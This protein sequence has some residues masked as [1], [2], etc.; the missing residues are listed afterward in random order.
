MPHEQAMSEKRHP[1]ECLIHRGLGRVEFFDLS[2]EHMVNLDPLLD[3]FSAEGRD[4]FSFHAPIMRPDDFP[5][6]GV[7]CFFLSEEK[8]LR[9]KSFSLL[10]RTLDEARRWGADYVVSHLT[11]GPSDTKN[12]DTALKL[13]REACARMAVMSAAAG[14]SLDLEFAAYSD[15]FH[16]AGDFAAAVSEHGELGV[17]I[18]IGHTYLGAHGRSRNYLD[19]IAAL[20]PRARSMH[21]WNT[22][23]PEHTKKHHHTPL[24]PSQRP[25]E[26]WLD[27]ESILGIVV[28]Q[29]PHIN[30][31]FEYPVETVTAEIQH[32]YDWIT[33]MIG[34]LGA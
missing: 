28:A 11:F 19:D 2:A 21:L 13:T 4:R 6:S 15:G 32:G 23:G 27:L 8:D 3:E 5:L 22:T 10:Q 20:A 24:H 12:P 1:S 34:R 18:D 16:D 9:E 25:V 30:I 14:V 33:E 7:T 31:V 29:N 26:G 17:C